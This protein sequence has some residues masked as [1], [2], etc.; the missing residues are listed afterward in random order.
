MRLNKQFY[1]R[2]AKASKKTGLAPIEVA[3]NVGGE[4]SYI[5]LELR[6]KP[7]QF[8]KDMASKKANVTK[9]YC[10]AVGNRLE[11]IWIEMVRKGIPLTKDNL[12]TY[13]R[14]GG[15][16]KIVTVDGVF[17]DYV[18]LK[19]DEYDAGKITKVTM[20]RYE[21]VGKMFCKYT[22]LKGSENAN[23]ITIA[24]W[25][26]FEL[27][28]QK[29]GYKQ[30]YISN[31]Q[32]KIRSAFKFAF[33]SGQI[34][35]H[36]FSMV[37]VRRVQNDI[38]YLTDEERD[39]VRNKTFVR[40]KHERVRDIFLFACCTALS[41]ADLVEVKKEDIKEKNK[42]YYLEGRRKKTGNKYVVPLTEEALR[43]LRKYDYKLPFISLTKYN[44]YLKEVGDICGID[45]PF[46]SHLAR[47]TGA[48]YLLNHG[49]SDE[50][51]AK[52]LG[53]TVEQVRRSYAEITNDTVLEKVSAVDKEE[54][55]KTF[56]QI[57]SE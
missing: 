6:A 45:K 41:Y 23:T 54:L 20:Q 44:Q 49:V 47:R 29:E 52:I 56:D 16:N 1:C 2:K 14:Q 35:A 37:Q 28:M 4:R 40:E 7:E 42:I 5:T 12:I 33:E 43:I 55:M 13:Y 27:G 10:E 34:D 21:T 15:L 26:A 17:A 9:D 22:G 53:D 46:T 24:H 38:I 8:D 39:I 31:W 36:P 30:N 19:K 50:I 32:K 51:V 11:E 48:T 3:V 25:K 18:A 57:L